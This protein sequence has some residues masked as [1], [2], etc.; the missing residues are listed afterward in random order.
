VP[1]RCVELGG[2]STSAETL[3][4]EYGIMIGS[5]RARMNAR[6]IIISP[7]RKRGRRLPY[8][9]SNLLSVHIHR[10]TAPVLAG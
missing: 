9:R 2:C 5:V 7:N 1:I 8:A 3:I 10:N 6:R 4:G